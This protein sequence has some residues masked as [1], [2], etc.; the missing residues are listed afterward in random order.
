MTLN[1][2]ATGKAVSMPAGLAM[3]AAVSLGMTL[4]LAVVTAKLVDSGVVRETGIG[5]CAMGILLLSAMAG[6][7]VS[8]GR[9]KRQRMA[10]CAMSGGIYYLTLLAMTALFFGGQYSG[11]GVTALVVLCGCALVLLPQLRKGRGQGRKAARKYRN[12]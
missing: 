8:S 10:V 4:G 5:Y 3:G 12:R 7:M 9:I 1:R 6:A 2:K 11:M